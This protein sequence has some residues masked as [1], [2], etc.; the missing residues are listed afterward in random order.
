MKKFQKILDPELKV[1]INGRFISLDDVEINSLKK[2][3]GL[4]SFD[5]STQMYRIFQ[6]CDQYEIDYKDLEFQHITS[7][8]RVE[9]SNVVPEKFKWMHDC[10]ICS[11]DWKSK[12]ISRSNICDRSH[13][14]L[15]RCIYSGK[16]IEKILEGRMKYELYD[17]RIIVY[18]KFFEN[19]SKQT[20]ANAML[21]LFKGT[22]NCVLILSDPERLKKK[23]QRTADTKKENG[24]FES[25]MKPG[26]CKMCGK[27]VENRSV[28]GVCFECNPG[29]K[30]WLDSLSEEEFR[31]FYESN[32]RIFAEIWKNR[33]EEE[34]ELIGNRISKS[35]YRYFDSL[36]DEQRKKLCVE[37]TDPDF[38]KFEFEIE[39]T[40]NCSLSQNECPGRN[41][42]KNKF[43][44]CETVVNSWNRGFCDKDWLVFDKH[45]NCNTK[46]EN[47]DQCEHRNDLK[48]SY[49]WCGFKL[50]APK[51]ASGKEYRTFDSTMKCN[52][53]CKFIR[54][55]DQNDKERSLKNYLGY[56][57]FSV[58]RS[59]RSA[60]TF[61]EYR[62]KLY[63]KNILT[64]KYLYVEDVI[65]MLENG[66]KISKHFMKIDGEW[67]YGKYHFRTGEIC[68]SQSKIK[69]LE[70]IG[71]KPDNKLYDLLKDSIIGIE[72]LKTVKSCVYCWYIMDYPFYVGE[73]KNLYNRSISHMT[74]IVYDPEYWCHALDLGMKIEIRM[75]KKYNVEVSKQQRKQDEIYY[76]GMLK[77]ISQKCDGTDYIKQLEER[78]YPDEILDKMKGGG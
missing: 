29:I 8:L 23:N 39:C 18:G 7:L 58:K 70:K 21:S 73:T 69:S 19:K 54:L 4:D 60:P 2:V 42:L 77:P 71:F 32:G 57:E 50:L 1:K 31:N 30:G 25:L 67:F 37:V 34:K 52:Q 43:G 22:N 62:G 38:M 53:E 12:I 63:W 51:G 35:L 11:L 10:K 40:L 36:T 27:W 16:P 59:G 45:M 46:C 78:I 48:N 26:L 49:G 6:I 72:C 64:Y 17:G 75:L 47:L 13:I 76:I 33:T 61:I 5:T 74:H 24:Y 41:V 14:I 66:E 68:H 28:T 56:C 9:K 44:Y 55:C 65:L 3:H 20:S 15:V